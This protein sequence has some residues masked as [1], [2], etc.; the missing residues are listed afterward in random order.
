MWVKFQNNPAGRNV[1]DCAVRAISKALSVDW[2]TAYAMLVAY[3][4]MLSDMPSSDAVSG[5]VLRKHGFVREALP[6]TCPEDNASAHG[7]IARTVFAKPDADETLKVMTGGIIDME[8]I[9][10]G[11]GQ[12]LS[13]AAINALCGIHFF[14]NGACIPSGGS[15]GGG[16]TPEIMAQI[17]NAQWKTEGEVTLFDESVTTVAGDRGNT[18]TLSYAEPITTDTLKVTFNGVKYTCPKISAGISVA[19]GGVTQT[20]PDFTEFPFAIISNSEGNMIYTET[21]GTYTIS[22]V[23]EGTIYT[24]EFEKAVK[25]FTGAVE[26]TGSDAPNKADIAIVT[27]PA[28]MS[29]EVQR[30]IIS[31]S[32]STFDTETSTL[33]GNTYIFYKGDTKGYVDNSQAFVSGVLSLYFRDRSNA[34]AIS[35]RGWVDFATSDQVHILNHVEYY[36]IAESQIKFYRIGLPTV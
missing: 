10:A 9:V 13:S 30:C 24:D 5:A 18:A 6:D 8:E 31:A 3:G 25:S 26:I 28:N 17:E 32:G 1:G 16:V 27:L 23:D 21:A 15:G 20:G 7:L 22:A 11:Y 2:E 35:S 36:P 34:W 19:Y 4:Y 33:F 29:A 12:E 14:K